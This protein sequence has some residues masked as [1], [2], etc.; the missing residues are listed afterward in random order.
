LNRIRKSSSLV[1]ALYLV[2]FQLGGFPQAQTEEAATEQNRNPAS[3]YYLE[4]GTENKLMMKVNV[5]GA[6][7]NP[8]AQYVPDQ[9]N[10]IGL[11]SV[12]GGPLENAK[13]S[14]VRLIRSFNGEQKNI[15]INV[16]KC[17]KKNEVEKIPEIKPGDTV[18]VPKKG[19][20]LGK[21]IN[22]IYNVAVIAS[23]VKLMTD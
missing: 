19:P 21:F 2:L 17:L 8:G 10:L 7:A 6:V 5:W 15:V 23:V 1:L 9:T 18:I 11:L 16:G 12:A 13:L 22:F 14:E 4:R 3:Q 20:S